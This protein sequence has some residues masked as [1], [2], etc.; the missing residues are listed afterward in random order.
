RASVQ[1][2]Q[3]TGVTALPP[4][5][6]PPQSIGVTGP[7]PSNGSSSAPNSQSTGVTALLPSAQ[8]PESTDVTGL[9]TSTVQPIQIG[10]LQSGGGISVVLPSTAP[11][12]T[13]Q[14]ILAQP[15]TV[16]HVTGSRRKRPTEEDHVSR[17]RVV[18]HRTELLKEQEIQNLIDEQLTADWITFQRVI[19]VHQTDLTESQ[20]QVEVLQKQLQKAKEDS[21]ATCQELEDKM[22]EHE[23]TSNA[24]RGT[25]A[26]QQN[27]LSKAMTKLQGS[28][29]KSKNLKEE[30]AKVQSEQNKLKAPVASATVTD[31]E[32]KLASLNAQTT[33]TI[34]YLESELQ[35]ANDTINGLNQTLQSHQQH[36]QLNSPSNTVGTE[37]Q[38]LRNEIDGL[39]KRVANDDAEQGKLKE[40]ISKLNKSNDDLS[41][42]EQRLKSQQEQALKAVE[43]KYEK[44][45]AKRCSKMKTDYDTALANTR[46]ELDKLKNQV[47]A[48]QGC[49]AVLESSE[50]QQLQD[51]TSLRNALE[52]EQNKN[53]V[54]LCDISPVLL[55]RLMMM[56]LKILEERIA[57][58]TRLEIAKPN[59]TA[60]SS[61]L[62]QQR[63][64]A[65][66]W[67]MG[68]NKRN[69]LS[70]HSSI[71]QG[72]QPSMPPS[73]QSLPTRLSTDE[74]M[75]TEDP[76]LTPRS[77]PG[78][79]TRLYSTEP[80]VPPNS[81]ASKP[82][83]AQPLPDD[84]DEM[85]LADIPKEDQASARMSLRS[86]SP[87]SGR[88][89]YRV[90]GVFPS[91]YSS[92]PSASAIRYT[93]KRRAQ[94]QNSQSSNSSTPST[95]G[96]NPPGLFRSRLA[97]YTAQHAGEATSRNQARAPSDAPRP[98]TTPSRAPISNSPTSSHSNRD[99]LPSSTSN[100]SPRHEP[101]ASPLLPVDVTERLLNCMETVANGVNGLRADLAN[102]RPPLKRKVNR[103]PSPY[104]ARASGRPRTSERTELT[105]KVQV[106]L[107]EC[108]S[109]PP[110]HQDKNIFGDISKAHLADPLE[111]ERFQ[112]HERE[113]PEM[114]PSSDESDG[115]GVKIVKILPWRHPKIVNT[116]ADTDKCL[117]KQNVYGGRRPGAQP[118]LRLRPRQGQPVSTKPAPK[119]WPSN[120]YHP[121]W[122]ESQTDLELDLLEPRDPKSFPGEHDK[123]DPALYH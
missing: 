20:K 84:N 80:G 24:L 30:L 85:Y 83:T 1:N 47:K 29:T 45:Y 18:G 48:G 62:S 19:N 38:A 40:E 104:K 7:P 110:D 119:G 82:N 32:T 11:P 59:N 108:L 71:V 115:P 34:K 35:K 58:V 64:T 79:R 111:V 94:L 105:D 116:L 113:P 98:P 73:N 61:S 117:P 54:G 17:V 31:L 69:G 63:E 6:Q 95:S 118:D 86:P 4:S 121:V 87:V 27:D 109:L 50:S 25:I 37:I 67:L 72:R 122:F 77:T 103:L 33:Q 112:N 68:L 100:T 114:V 46:A 89:R 92:S 39:R 70:L 107:R 57:N 14:S 88:D 49:I 102:S 91:R 13:I 99:E 78:P 21:K 53:T 36:A 55:L 42:V 10:H 43:E 96:V 97:A 9:L 66:I 101:S 8:P 74:D 28:Q 26:N 75:D 93:V 60:P 23:Q 90:P 51:T 5:A 12:S 56:D 123:I 120:Y 3:F 16:V 41:A 65:R 22:A 76:A 2:S 44:Q 106:F 81:A 15:P 52:A